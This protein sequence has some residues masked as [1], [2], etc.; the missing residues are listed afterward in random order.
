M[1][2]IINLDDLPQLESVKV[3]NKIMK[4]LG[5]TFNP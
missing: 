3:E 1:F 4:T 5:G 2:V